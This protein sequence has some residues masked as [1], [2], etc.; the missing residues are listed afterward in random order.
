MT[1]GAPA[2]ARIRVRCMRRGFMTLS[3]TTLVGAAR[4]CTDRPQLNSFAKILL[5]WY[6]HYIVNLTDEY[7]RRLAGC[8]FVG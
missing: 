8:R 2:G 5:V 6:L 3:A 1:E 4:A 7:P